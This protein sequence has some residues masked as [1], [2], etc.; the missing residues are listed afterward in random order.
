M[1]PESIADF[2]RRPEW[3]YAKL[4]MC[5]ARDD[6]VRKLAS[7]AKDM[8][9]VARLQ[10]EIGTLTVVIGDDKAAMSLRDYM[11]DEVLESL[12]D[13]EKENA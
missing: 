7:D 13:Q 10:Q 6:A 3:E 9:E 1:S 11:H 4:F 8:A 12:K 5:E 2:F